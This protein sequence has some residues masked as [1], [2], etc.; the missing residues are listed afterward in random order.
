MGPNFN[1]FYVRNGVVTPIPDETEAE[2]LVNKP[3]DLDAIAARA[4]PGSIAYTA[5]KEQEWQLSPDHKWVPKQGV[6]SHPDPAVFSVAPID[7]D[8]VI[9]GHTISDL[10]SNIFVSNYA[11]Y[12][13]LAYV[14]TG[15]LVTDW[16][17]GHFMGL[18]FGGSAFNKAK[19]IYVGLD[20]SVSSGLVDVIND[21]DKNGIFKVTDK[22]QDFVVILDYG[23]YTEKYVYSLDD[24]TLTAVI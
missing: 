22:V 24:L 18:Q 2:Y 16:G 19:H 13:T 5:N 6:Y 17:A 3:S 10:Q 20:P 21:P 12:G 1:R 11:I 8:T 15:Q 23:S 7:G 9:W 4:I 14:S